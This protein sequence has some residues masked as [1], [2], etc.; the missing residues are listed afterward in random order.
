M[1]RR[2][3]VDYWKKLRKES[4]AYTGLGD[5]DIEWYYCFGYHSYLVDDKEEKEFDTIPNEKAR[6]AAKMGYI[7]AQ[8]DYPE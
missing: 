4:L 5:D 6:E 8:G 1:N 7:D 2:Q 3:A